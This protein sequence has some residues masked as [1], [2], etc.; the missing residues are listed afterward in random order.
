MLNSSPG[1]ALFS[2]LRT[3]MGTSSSQPV[4]SPSRVA[5]ASMVAS[6]ATERKAHFT[7]DAEMDDVAASQQLMD[8]EGTRAAADGRNGDDVDLSQIN[9]SHNPPSPIQKK[10]KRKSAHRSGNNS[11]A[12]AQD[13]LAPSEVPTSSPFPFPATQPEAESPA[14]NGSKHSTAIQVPDSQVPVQSAYAYASS[15]TSAHAVPCSAT[16][17][18]RTYK[19]SKLTKRDRLSRDAIDEQDHDHDHD[20][21]ISMLLEE[22]LSPSHTPSKHKRSQV[23]DAEP[24]SHGEAK[25][26]DMRKPATKAV[27]ATPTPKRRKI[28]SAKSATRVRDLIQAGPQDGFDEDGDLLRSVEKTKLKRIKKPQTPVTKSKN[29]YEIPDDDPR[30]TN[31]HGENEEASGDNQAKEDVETEAADTN[32]VA[33]SG[34]AGKVNTPKVTSTRSLKKTKKTKDEVH[35]S[36]TPVRTPGQPLGEVDNEDSIMREPVSNDEDNYHGPPAGDD[37]RSESKKKEK[38][39]KRRSSTKKATP[40][41]ES[42]K[43]TYKRKKIE[44][45]TAA[46]RALAGV[47]HDLN[48]PPDLREAGDFTLDEEELI[49]RAVRD[50]QDRKELDVPQLVRIIQWSKSDPALNRNNGAVSGKNDWSPQDINNARESAEFW[51]DIKNITTKRSLERMRKHIRQTY[52]MFKSGAWTDEEDQL[53]KNLYAQHPNKWKMI[54]VGMGDRSMHDCQNRWRDYLQYGD[55]LKSSRWEPEEEELFIRAITTVAQ[56]DEDYRAEQGLPPV[57]EY[58]ITHIDW[59]QVSREMD[60]T[61]S[62]IQVVAKWKNL[63]KRDPPPRIQVEHKPRKDKPASSRLTASDPIPKKRGRPRKSERETPK[64]RHNGKS[65]NV[66]DKSDDEGVDAAPPSKKRGRPEQGE[67]SVVKKSKKFR[68]I[69]SDEIVDDSGEEGHAKQETNGS[70]AKKQRGKS[71]RTEGTKGQ[72]PKKARKSKV[73]DDIEDSNNEE[74]DADQ[75]A[76]NS[77]PPPKKRGRPRKT[78][79]ESDE[80]KKR[81]KSKLLNESVE[82]LELQEGEQAERVESDDIAIEGFQPDPIDEVNGDQPQEDGSDTAQ[83]RTDGSGTGSSS[84]VRPNNVPNQQLDGGNEK[85]RDMD[86]DEDPIEDE[87]DQPSVASGSPAKDLHDEQSKASSDAASQKQDEERPGEEEQ[88]PSSTHVDATEDVSDAQSEA[89]DDAAPQKQDEEHLGEEEPELDDVKTIKPDSSDTDDDQSEDDAK[90]APASQLSHHSPPSISANPQ[91]NSPVPPSPL[92]GTKPTISGTPKMQWGDI[93]DLIATLQE[94]RDEE[95]GDV[96]WNGIAEEM[97]S[98][99]S[100]I[101]HV[102]TLRKALEEMVQLLRDNDKEV[103][104]EDLPGTVDDVMDYISERHGGSVEEYFDLDGEGLGQ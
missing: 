100:Y 69:E 29:I 64:A 55:K 88:E 32:G 78:E 48:H 84:S 12:T 31:G 102:D 57:D 45:N 54:E 25:D 34:N 72:K 81:R 39:K 18:K 38:K 65:Q 37:D 53:L 19:K 70:P 8:E 92:S 86:E 49:R 93:Y 96:D 22:A 66:I 40:R 67:S 82:D 56:R 94:R 91:H 23:D 47:N 3:T 9:G 30:P 80:P 77:P 51:N 16:K 68:M 71:R 76:T 46:E 44:T 5:P 62:R 98:E 97:T 90:D 35:D 36:A 1:Y 15:P 61:R 13:M 63:Q 89:N 27:D 11:I 58:T 33:Q 4:Q 73:R 74:V 60:N 85:P 101:W 75:R 17:S 6:P 99:R 41:R 104:T 2:D 52:H 83:K 43:F 26:I 14:V 50:F 42:G 28:G 10:R 7:V 59:P 103:D 24:E 21:D 95:E 87:D 20:R 79:V